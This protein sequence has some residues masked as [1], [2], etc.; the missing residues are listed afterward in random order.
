M[1]ISKYATPTVI[2]LARQIRNGDEILFPILAD[3]LQDIG[4]SHDSYDPEKDFQ[5]LR[6]ENRRTNYIRWNIIDEILGR[7]KYDQLK[8]EFGAAQYCVYRK[9]TNDRRCKFFVDDPGELIRFVESIGL[10][11]S[12]YRHPMYPPREYYS[13]IIYVIIPES[14]YIQGKRRKQKQGT[15]S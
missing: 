2:A 1:E 12:S 7:T 5:A 14:E 9:Q 3:A 6:K 15:N 10:K 11:C 8:D 13:R 4:Y